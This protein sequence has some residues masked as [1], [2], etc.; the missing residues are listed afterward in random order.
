[1]EIYRQNSAYESR[2]ESC[3]VVGRSKQYACV[4]FVYCC[5]LVILLYLIITFMAMCNERMA[6]FSLSH[7]HTHTQ[8]IV[9]QL[10]VFPH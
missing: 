1:M 9:P 5:Q 8:F 3:L 2:S 7:T 10:K 6:S 4:S